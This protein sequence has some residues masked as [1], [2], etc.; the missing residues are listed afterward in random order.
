MLTIFN[1]DGCSMFEK[2]EPVDSNTSAC[3]LITAG[4]S[5]GSKEVTEPSYQ[6]GTCEPIGGDAIG[7]VSLNGP[8][9]FCCQ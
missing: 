1:D 6:P 5:L 7:S 2:S 3:I 4:A 9:T 8:S